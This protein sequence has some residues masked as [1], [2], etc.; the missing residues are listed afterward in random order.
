MSSDFTPSRQS[1][2]PLK[3]ALVLADVD[4]PRT[5]DLRE[6]VEIVADNDVAVP[7]SIE[8]ARWLTPWAAQLRYEMLEP[9]DRDARPSQRRP[10]PSRGRLRCSWADWRLRT[11][12]R[13]SRVAL[14]SQKRETP[15]SGRSLVI[16]FIG[17]KTDETHG[18]GEGGIRTRDG[19]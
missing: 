18:D 12:R 19:V 4:F 17:P 13:R 16:G 5:H 1:R 10:T 3:V 15:M 14:G 6:L 9:L 2:R 8:Q 11:P 7:D